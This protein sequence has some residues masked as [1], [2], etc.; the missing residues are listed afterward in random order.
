MVLDDPL[1]P[2]HVT[3]RMRVANFAIKWPMHSHCFHYSATD[4]DRNI[5]FGSKYAWMDIHTNLT[6]KVQ[7]WRGLG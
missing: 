3:R 2:G 7:K 6:L 4:Q 1:S 5:K